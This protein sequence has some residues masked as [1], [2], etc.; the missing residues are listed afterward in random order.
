LNILSSN[1]KKRR[2]FPVSQSFN[3]FNSSSNVSIPK[4]EVQ[5]SSSLIRSTQYSISPPID[6]RNPITWNVNDVCWYLNESGC[7]FALKTI[8]E[9]VN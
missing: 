1:K 7:S 4:I 6:P 5:Q 8:K 3:D 9:Q 2:P